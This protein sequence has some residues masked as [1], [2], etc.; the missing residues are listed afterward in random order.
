MTNYWWR[1][2]INCVWQAILETKI[3][4][5]FSH[6]KGRHW[7]LIKKEE[8]RWMLIGLKMSIEP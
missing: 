7:W 6:T 2:H 8:V 1:I 3:S 4:K 5:A